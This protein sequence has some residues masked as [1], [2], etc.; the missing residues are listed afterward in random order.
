VQRQV[1]RQLQ[2]RARERELVQVHQ[3]A[4]E[5]ELVRVQQR[6]R[7]RGPLRAAL[8]ERQQALVRAPSRRLL[9]RVQP[10]PRVPVRARRPSQWRSEAAPRR[11]RR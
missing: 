2:H 10:L 8:R 1:Q 4:R 3:R 9:A 6:V 5:R 7:L 11:E